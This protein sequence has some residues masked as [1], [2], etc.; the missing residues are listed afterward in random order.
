VKESSLGPLGQ[1]LRPRLLAH[2][3]HSSRTFVPWFQ[4]FCGARP[5]PKEKSGCD[6]VSPATGPAAHDYAE[7]WQDPSAPVLWRLLNA[8]L[9]FW[10]HCGA[11]L[12]YEPFYVSSSPCPRPSPPP[13]RSAPATCLTRMP[14][15]RHGC[16]FVPSCR[17]R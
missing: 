9:S 17:P 7:T 1:Y 14:H 5:M 11:F 4:Q 2:V 6:D 10:F 16:S 3:A 12:G 13:P 15:P 8:F